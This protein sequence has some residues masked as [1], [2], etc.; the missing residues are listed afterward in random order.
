MAHP[1]SNQHSL[2]FPNADVLA[3]A[4][5]DPN[6]YSLSFPNA[7]VLAHPNQYSLPFS[8]AYIH[9]IKARLIDHALC[10]R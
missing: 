4:N 10:Q 9:I 8:N 7:D 5:T 6:Q 1:N 3:H 2:S